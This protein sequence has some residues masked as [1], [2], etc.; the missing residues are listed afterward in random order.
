VVPDTVTLNLK[1]VAPG[2]YRLAVGWYDA[3]GRLPAL[4]AN[5]QPLADD[6]VVLPET[7]HLP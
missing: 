6:Q 5:N 7:L 1:N 2:D 3:T 4:D